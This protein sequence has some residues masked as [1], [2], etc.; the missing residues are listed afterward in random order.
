MKLACTLIS[1]ALLAGLAGAL[2]AAAAPSVSLDIYSVAAC[3]DTTTV[4]V[5]G[6]STYSNNRVEAALYY[7]D[8]KG[9]DVFL[10]QNTSP[11]FSSGPFMLSL[12]LSYIANSARENE[13]LRLDVRHLKLSASGKSYEVVS[14][15]TRNVTVADKYCFGKCTVTVDTTDKAPAAGTLTLRSHFGA[16]FRPEGWLHGAFPVSAGLKARVVFVGLPCDWPVRAWY[17]PRTGDKIPKMLPAQYWPN[18]FQANDLDGT[19]P[20]TA[21]FARGLKPTHPLESNDPFVVK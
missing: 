6:S 13:V 11:V 3:K 10:S 12:T 20:Y 14:T 15:T 9:K 7:R 17:Y 8:D 5:A 19:N 4:V 21:S 1:V 16:W 2:P 18:E